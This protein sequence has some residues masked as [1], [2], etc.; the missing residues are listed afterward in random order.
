MPSGWFSSLT[1]PA[2]LLLCASVC[3]P[4]GRI[5]LLVSKLT[6]FMSSS[7]TKEIGESPQKCFCPACY[8]VRFRVIFSSILSLC[9][10]GRR[11]MPRLLVLDPCT[12]WINTYS[13]LA[14]ARN[15]FVRVVERQRLLASCLSH[16]TI[17]CCA[18]LLGCKPH[19]V[20]DCSL[21]GKWD[22]PQ[23]VQNKNSGGFVFF[24]EK[25]IWLQ[26]DWSNGGACMTYLF[27]VNNFSAQTLPTPHL[28][29]SGSRCTTIYFHYLIL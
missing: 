22:I 28:S 4:M 29:L 14:E 24:N 26:F 13:P 7:A 6:W 27:Q 3:Y 19:C 5:G 2:W 25:Q 18:Y 17:L 21:R 15:H 1:L 8:A 9:K 12:C 11:Q 16:S 20:S 23:N 10:M